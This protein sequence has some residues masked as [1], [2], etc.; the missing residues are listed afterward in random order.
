MTLLRRSASV[1]LVISFLVAAGGSIALAD[2]R[3]CNKTAS[4]VGVAIGYK[5]DND[6]TSEGW[7]TVDSEACATILA[8]PLKSRYYYMYAVDYDEGGEWGGRSA[9]FCTREKEFTIEGAD[10]CVAKGYQRTGFY[11]VDTGQQESWT[12]QLT[13]PMSQGVGGR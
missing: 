4:R 12:I 7:W 10:N 9:Y 6:W 13:E 2:L 8:G 3:V 1:A 5:S 11:E